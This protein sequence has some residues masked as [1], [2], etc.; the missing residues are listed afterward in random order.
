MYLLYL[1]ESGNRQ[2][3]HFVVGGLAIHEQDAHRYARAVDALFRRL[4][5]QITDGEIHAQ[6]IRAGKGA[7][8]AVQKEVRQRIT[9]DI[10]TLLTSTQHESDRMTLP[11]TPAKMTSPRC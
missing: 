6:H 8:R 9:D 11:N 5:A 7:W 10:A 2:S 4:P 1:D 3:E